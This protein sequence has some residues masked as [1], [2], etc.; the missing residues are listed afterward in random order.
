MNRRTILRIAGAGGATGLGGCLAARRPGDD[1]AAGTDGTSPG[2]STDTPGEADDRS[3]L[4]GT[5]EPGI[6]RTVS[7]VGVD[8]GP[9]RDRR[10]VA[11]EVAVLEP[12]IGDEHTARVRVD[13]RNRSDESRTLT[14]VREVC[15]LNLLAGSH[16]ER[17]VELLL[18]AAAWER[19]T[20]DCWRVNPRTLS[21]GIPATEHEVDLDPGQQVGWEFAAWSPPGTGER[22]LP[23][24]EYRF[25]RPFDPDGDAA[26]LSFRL[27]VERPDADS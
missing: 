20:T 6:P 2:D 18:V 3:G 8:D 11:A 23:P 25:A 19:T 27:G 4:T 5:P 7:L 24:G 15:D 22:C 13:L 16:H 10:D 21:C 17:D 26:T 14:Y 1:P 9:L 12:R